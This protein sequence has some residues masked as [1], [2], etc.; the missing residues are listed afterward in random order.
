MF[1]NNISEN[2]LQQFSIDSKTQRKI[3]QYAL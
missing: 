1:Q 3:R 2:I